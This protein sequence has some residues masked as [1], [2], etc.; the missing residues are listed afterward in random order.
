MNNITEITD[1]LIPELSMYSNTNEKQLFRYYEPEHGIFIAESAKVIRRALEAGYE[2][3]SILAERKSITGQAADI[4]EK[5]SSIP[6]YTA[7][8]SVLTG[9]TGFNL[10]QGIL[11]AMRRISLPSVSEI[12]SDAVRIAV[13]ED[14]C[15]IIIL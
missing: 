13:L 15:V 5:C 12:C 8:S 4:I 14:I 1:L 3:L 11:C 10:T 7:D 2:P 9:I 6:V